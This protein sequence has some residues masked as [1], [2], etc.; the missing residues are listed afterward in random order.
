M[1]DRNAPFS[2]AFLGLNV[3]FVVVEWDD[4]VEEL[5]QFLE[6]LE[7]AKLLLA[8]VLQ[9]LLVLLRDRSVELHQCILR[10]SI[11][12]GPTLDRGMSIWYMLCKDGSAHTA[13]ALV[14]SSFNVRILSSSTSSGRYSLLNIWQSTFLSS[15]SY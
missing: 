2:S 12:R 10:Y 1:R 6:L 8:E 11:L 15:P 4:V 13:R 3:I 14:M 7:L 5:E 9:L